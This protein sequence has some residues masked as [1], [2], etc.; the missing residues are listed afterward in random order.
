[1]DTHPELDAL[2]LG[3]LGIPV[4]HA[5]L[6]LHSAAKGVHH[7]REL[8]EHA[9]SGCLDDPSVVLG[10]LGVYE[11]SAVALEL[12]KRTFFVS[13]HEAAIA[14]HIRGKNSRKTTLRAFEHCFPRSM[15]QTLDYQSTDA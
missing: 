5:T 12:S 9:I 2:I 14:N 10:D 3:Y 4:S 11:V 13:A 7:A 6:N 8:D 1:V 15:V